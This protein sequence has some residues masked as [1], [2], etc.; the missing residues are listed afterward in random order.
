MSVRKRR[1]TTASG[2]NK[3]AWVVDY[4]DKDG[5]HSETFTRKKDADER[6]AEV[7]VNIKKGT[8]I[9]PSASITVA[10]AAE[11]WI[12]AGVASDLERGT[13]KNYKT[14][15]A[16]RINPMIGATKLCDLNVQAVVKVPRSA[17]RTRCLTSHR[18]ANDLIPWQHH[19]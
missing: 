8:H 18:K 14:A 15:V 12:K 5:R 2:E 17:S 13:L 3:E 1:W 10:E 19:R 16:L 6:H 9:A 7:K 11:S 4:T